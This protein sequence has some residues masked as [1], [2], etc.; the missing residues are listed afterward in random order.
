MLAAMLSSIVGKM[1]PGQAACR[2]A[3]HQ[4]A[5]TAKDDLAQYA[6]SYSAG[7]CPRCLVEAEAFAMARTRMTMMHCLDRTGKTE[8]CSHANCGDG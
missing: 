1:V 8:P 7:C 4:A 3:D 5:S 6:A 2:S